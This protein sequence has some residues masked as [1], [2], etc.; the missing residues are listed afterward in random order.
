MSQHNQAS[1]HSTL[2]SS[3][4]LLIDSRVRN[5]ESSNLASNSLF[6]Y[7]PRPASIVNESISCFS[8]TI[9]KLPKIKLLHETKTN[10]IP[11]G[12]RSVIQD[13]RNIEEDESPMPETNSHPVHVALLQI[14][15]HLH[16]NKLIE[17]YNAPC[18]S[19]YNAWKTLYN[20]WECTKKQIHMKS[21]SEKSRLADEIEPIVS[22][23]LKYPVAG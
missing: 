3:V 6:E 20:D 18:D 11:R 10:T 21:F 22:L 13:V 4:T 14:E 5:S 17:G 7:L 23:V 12:S 15:K 2:V 1:L 9:E 16:I 19:L 8:G